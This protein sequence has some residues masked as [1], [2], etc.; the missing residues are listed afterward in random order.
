M[1]AGHGQCPEKI[2]TRLRPPLQGHAGSFKASTHTDMTTT[3]LTPYFDPYALIAEHIPPGSPLFAI[4]MPHASM[5]AAKAV[6]AGKRL[7]LSERGLRF[8]Q[9]AALLHDIGIIHTNEPKLHCHGSLPYIQHGVEGRRMLEVR[10]LFA[11]ARVAES[12]VG[13]GMAKEEIEAQ[14]LGL[15]RRDMLPE[16]IEEKLVCWA[17]KFFS[18]NPGQLWSEL[19]FEVAAERIARHGEPSLQRFL[20]LHATCTKT[21]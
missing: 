9:D 2:S 18:K 5:V 16:T 6:N 7:G 14:G 1:C 15:P 21:P 17:D 4:F 19:S 8:V 20:E 12:H 13:A 11:L 10:G 3:P